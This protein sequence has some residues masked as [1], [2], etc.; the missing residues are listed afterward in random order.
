VDFTLFPIRGG[1][2]ASAIA[3]YSKLRNGV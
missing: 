3:I 2:A 1:L